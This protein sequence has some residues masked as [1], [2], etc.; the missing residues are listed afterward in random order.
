[1]KQINVAVMISGGGSNLQALLDAAETGQIPVCI[2]L[3]IS[4]RKEAYGIT[5]A[6]SRDIP[7]KVLPETG[8]PESV[9]E[10]TLGW[11]AEAGV[12]LVVL[13]GYLKKIPEKVVDAYENRII[14]VHPSLIPAFSG[15]G[16]YGMEV[17]RAAC[18]RGVKITGA[19]VHF[20]DEGMDEG[21]IIMQEAIALTGD[22]SPEEIGERVLKIEHRLLPN[23]VG[24]FA[25]KRLQVTDGKVKILERGDEK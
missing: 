7:V 3:V 10:L 9:S 23:A 1:M 2:R 14:N 24:L 13:A 8:N 5:R 18:R 22:E 16:Y 20:V 11:L 4:S 19:T 25:E 21:P 12:D 6:R 17:H 15:P